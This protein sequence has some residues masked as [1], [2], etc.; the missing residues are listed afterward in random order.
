MSLLI[1]FFDLACSDCA[2]FTGKYVACFRVTDQCA[3]F[4]DC[5]FDD[6]S[7]RSSVDQFGGAMQF[8]SGSTVSLVDSVFHQCACVGSTSSFGGAASL[9]AS[10]ITIMGSCLSIEEAAQV[11]ESQGGAFRRSEAI[12]QDSPLDGPRITDAFPD[13]LSDN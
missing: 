10:S 5:L 13:D 8:G 7:S 3:T 6:I 4:L 11:I 9:T 1:L 12:S 2:L